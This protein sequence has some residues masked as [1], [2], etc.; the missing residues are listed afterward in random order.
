MRKILLVL[1]LCLSGIVYGQVTDIVVRI[2]DCP[3]DTGYATL[4]LVNENEGVA[5]KAVAFIDST[6]VF[7]FSN[8]TLP[9]A[10]YTMLLS[11][12]TNVNSPVFILY[13]NSV[14][15]LTGTCLTEFRF[16]KYDSTQSN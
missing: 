6:L 15:L 10:W 8:I 7:E 5:V 3:F 1:L 12:Y 11:I 9:I 13:V 4:W 16:F 14:P 2:S